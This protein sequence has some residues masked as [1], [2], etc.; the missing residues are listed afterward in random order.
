MSA[1]YGSDAVVANCVSDGFST[2]K[3]VFKQCGI[4]GSEGGKHYISHPMNK[5]RNI[6]FFNDVPQLLKCT[7]NHMLMHKTVQV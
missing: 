4:D 3:A 7:R 1:L 6:Y 5:D 2:N